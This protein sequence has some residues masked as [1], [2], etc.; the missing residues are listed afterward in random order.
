MLCLRCGADPVPPPLRCPHCDWFLGIAAEGQGFLPQLRE[1]ERS[2]ADGEVQREQA[3]E[4]LGRLGLGLEALAAETAQNPDADWQKQKAGDIAANLQKGK[5]GS[6]REMFTAKDREIF[7]QVA[8][9]TL[10]SRGYEL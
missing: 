3:E 2:L 6:W 7:H 5:H 1:L 10:K 4:M 9:E 8:G